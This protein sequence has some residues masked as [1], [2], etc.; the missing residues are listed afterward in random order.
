VGYKKGTFTP[1]ELLDKLTEGHV[2]CH[3]FDPTR[4]R[5]RKDRTF[6]NSE[7]KNENFRCSYIIGVDIDE[8]K[9]KTA[10]DFIEKLELKPTFYYTSYRNQ[11]EGLG[12]RIRMIYIFIQPIDSPYL[13]RYFSWKLHKKIEKDTKEKIKDKDLVYLVNFG[14][15]DLVGC[16]LEHHI[17]PRCSF[18]AG[19]YNHH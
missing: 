3:I 9:Y 8:T 15:D 16:E 6:G 12:A 13:F 14:D 11:Q 17:L 18:T 1:Q 7:K 2:F 19:V 10:E 5:R 4:C